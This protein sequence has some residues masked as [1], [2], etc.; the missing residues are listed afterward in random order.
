MSTNQVAAPAAVVTH[1]AH[2]TQPEHPTGAASLLPDEPAPFS[3]VIPVTRSDRCG[4]R[5]VGVF[6]LTGPSVRWRPAIDAQ[7]LAERGQALAALGCA[8]AVVV[9]LT[10]GWVARRPVVGPVSMGPGGWLSVRGDVARRRPVWARLLRA[11]RVS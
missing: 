8:T 5:T 2:V 3:A 4:T 7:R 11:R 10:R 9:V 1:H 6:D